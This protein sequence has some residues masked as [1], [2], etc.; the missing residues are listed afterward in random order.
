MAKIVSPN[1][2]GSGV[3]A[4]M[5]SERRDSTLKNRDRSPANVLA[6]DRPFSRCHLEREP[7]PFVASGTLPVA[8][9]SLGQK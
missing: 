8:S 9:A 1:P 6:N 3:M 5:T 7:K 4:V 2:S